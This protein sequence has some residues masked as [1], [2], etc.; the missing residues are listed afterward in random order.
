MPPRRPSK[1]RA[2]PTA[3]SEWRPARTGPT[4]CSTCGRPTATTCCWRGRASSRREA[5]RRSGRT[6]DPLGLGLGHEAEHVAGDP[7]HLDLLGTLGDPVAA[8]VA[9]DVLE[10]GVARVAHAPV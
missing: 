4:A 6:G 10:R 7:A 1:P 8:V 2:W 9:V 3:R 5:R